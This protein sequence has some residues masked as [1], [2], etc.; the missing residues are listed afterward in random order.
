MPGVCIIFSI[1]FHQLKMII[2]FQAKF[3]SYLRMDTR[4]L[5]LHI[6]SV[7]SCLHCH[8]MSQLVFGILFSLSLWFGIGPLIVEGKFLQPG[9]ILADKH[10][11]NH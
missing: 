2:K 8:Y 9:E 3:L 4:N 11:S 5:S 7:L 1:L 10:T 6:R